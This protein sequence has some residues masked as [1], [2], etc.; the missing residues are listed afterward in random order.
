MCC[1]MGIVLQAP[2]VLVLRSPV[3]CAVMCV[4]RCSRSVNPTTNCPGTLAVYKHNPFMSKIY[5]RGVTE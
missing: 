5:M 4:M 1:F 2:A 3:V